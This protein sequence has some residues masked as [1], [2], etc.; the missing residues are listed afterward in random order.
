MN[1]NGSARAREA[2][3]IPE[4]LGAVKE[5]REEAIDLTKPNLLTSSGDG[6]TRRTTWRGSGMGCR[7][8][9]GLPH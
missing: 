8:G 4:F 7:M 6:S 9:I 3:D 1:R 5:G 2:R